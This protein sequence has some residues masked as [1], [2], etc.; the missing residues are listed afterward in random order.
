MSEINAIATNNYLLATQQEVSHDNTLSGNGTVDSPL[1]VVPGYN[2]TVLWSGACLTQGGAAT[3]AESAS[4]F[5]KIEIYAVP[6]S[7]TTFNFPQVFTY[8]G[9]NTKGAY[10]CQFMTDNTK[11]RFGVGIWTITNGTSFNLVAA[12]Q[13]DSY[14]TVNWNN[15]YGGV[16][17]IVGINRKA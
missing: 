6:N 8:P 14:P 10:M 4:N 16:V 7:G 3:L 5:E 2:E 17:K 12:G 11:G 15:S 9:D 13:T 1:G